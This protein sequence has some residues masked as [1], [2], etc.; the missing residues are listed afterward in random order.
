MR[1]DK[2]RL[3]GKIC[4][5]SVSSRDNAHGRLSEVSGI[6]F[7]DT[8]ELECHPETIRS[9]VLI[10]GMRKDAEK[11]KKMN[12]VLQLEMQLKSQAGRN[13]STMSGKRKNWSW[14]TPDKRSWLCLAGVPQWLSSDT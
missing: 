2:K 8:A 3:L 10:L 4:H 14:L 11:R 6:E 13:G 9:F 1:M 7:Q 12:P 5:G